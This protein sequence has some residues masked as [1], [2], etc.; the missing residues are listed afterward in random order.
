MRLL[1]L[2]L[3]IFSF[4]SCQSQNREILFINNSGIALDSVIIAVSSAEVLTVKKN[5]FKNGDSLINKIPKGKP[6]SNRHDITV[7]VTVFINGQKPIYEYS[8]NDLTGELLADYIITLERDKK[9][10][11]KT[12]ANE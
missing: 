1:F 3:I 5:N 7:A 6:T 11:W 9:F 2:L 10:I 4:C 12:K 8:Y